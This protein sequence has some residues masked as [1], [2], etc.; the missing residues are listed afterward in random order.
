MANVSRLSSGIDNA[1]L[2]TLPK[3]SRNLTLGAMVVTR[4]ARIMSVPLSLRLAYNEL[5]D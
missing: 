2:V 5:E 3:D 4:H 1:S